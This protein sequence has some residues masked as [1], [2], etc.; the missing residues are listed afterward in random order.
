MPHNYLKTSYA[1]ALAI[2]GMLATAPVL[3]DKHAGKGHEKAEKHERREKQSHDRE[4]DDRPF[5]QKGEQDHREQRYFDDRHRAVIHDYYVEQ[6][7]TGRCPPGLA[8]KQNG[9][10]P[11]G[12]ARQWNIGQ[13]LPRNVTYYDLPSAVLNQLGAPLPGHRYVRVADD[14]LLIRLGTGL[15]VDALQGLGWR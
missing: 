14:V 13:P 4:R 5:Q 15:V 10:V 8:K 12:L 11:P 2:A 9:C 6:F 7:R 3:A 1:L